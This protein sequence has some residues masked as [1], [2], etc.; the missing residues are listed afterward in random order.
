MS[1]NVKFYDHKLTE[2]FIKRFIEDAKVTFNDDKWIE[3]PR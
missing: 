2:Y 1:A 3:L